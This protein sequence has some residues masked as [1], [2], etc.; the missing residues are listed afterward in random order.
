MLMP[1][2]ILSNMPEIA[3]IIFYKIPMI[4]KNK[5]FLDQSIFMT[6]DIQSIKLKNLNIFLEFFIE[7]RNFNAIIAALIAPALQA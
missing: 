2:M 5:G 6:E 4:F 3:D 1:Q 7:F